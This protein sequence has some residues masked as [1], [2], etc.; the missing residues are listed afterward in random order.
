[1]TVWSKCAHSHLYE[2]QPYSSL[3]KPTS[4]PIVLFQLKVWFH[5]MYSNRIFLVARESYDLLIF[6]DNEILF[7]CSWCNQRVG[8]SAPV[9]IVFVDFVQSTNW[10]RGVKGCNPVSLYQFVFHVP[11]ALSPC[12]G[13][14]VGC[15][16]NEYQM[17]I[18]HIWSVTHIDT[19]IKF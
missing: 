5:L 14:N 2:L 16:W 10:F 12:R 6:H 11:L 17:C 13:L 18:Q 1:M 9:H 4:Y 15:N 7:K 8:I 19:F 3:V